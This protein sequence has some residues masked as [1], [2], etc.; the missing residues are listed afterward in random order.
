MGS[1]SVHPATILLRTSFLLKTRQEKSQRIGFNIPQADK[2]HRVGTLTDNSIFS[3]DIS[4]RS[5]MSFY[6]YDGLK[7]VMH[8]GFH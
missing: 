1:L 8:L 5:W 6:L 7:T 4:S 3:E 2:C